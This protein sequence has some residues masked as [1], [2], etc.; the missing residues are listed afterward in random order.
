MLTLNLADEARW[1][2]MQL[3]S[4]NFIYQD[5][6]STDKDQDYCLWIRL[7]LHANSECVLLHFG[8]QC[9]DLEILF[10]YSLSSSAKQSY[11]Q[12]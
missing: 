7:Y 2:K 9:R 1:W 6:S 8:G 10:H 5:Q 12:F 3:T 4:P 11:F